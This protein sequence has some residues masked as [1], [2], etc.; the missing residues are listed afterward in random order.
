MRASYSSEI[1]VRGLRLH[2]R[3]WLTEGADEHSPVL[4][5]LHGWM[6]VSASFQFLVDSLARPWHVVA[7]DWRGFGLSGRTTGQDGVAS[8]WMPDYYADLEVMLDRLG[9]DRAHLVG[10]SMGGNIAA[11]Y[12]GIR[13]ERVKT[14][15]LL[16]SF[17]LGETTPD[18]APDRYARWLDELREPPRLHAYADL[19]RVAS[20]LRKNNPR[21]SADKAEWLAPHWASAGDDGKWHLNADPAHRLI[22]PV[23]YQIDEAIACWQRVAAP[24]LWVQAAE[25]DVRFRHGSVDRSTFVTR[26]RHFRNV[27]IEIVADSGHMVHHDQPQVLAGLVESFVPEG[28]A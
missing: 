16:D 12:A 2:L 22:N 15:T 19:A 3:H 6:D 17:G 10:H 18:M 1:E 5:M 8:Y 9:L 14:I 25:T 23:L 20:R 13:P 11:F 27:R 7:P 28:A 21:L 26:A 4:L 24:V